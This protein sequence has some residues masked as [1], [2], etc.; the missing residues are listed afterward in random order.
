[1]SFSRIRFA[2]ILLAAALSTPA[3]AATP[4]P[5]EKINVNEL[6]SE[7]QKTSQ[8]P[9][10]VDL[11][12][13]IPEQFWAA[14]MAQD[15]NPDPR[16]TKEL[17]EVFRRNV[18]VATL[19]GE[20][21]VM[22]IGDFE[23]EEVLRGK[24]RVLGPDGKLLAPI[25]A[26]KVERKLDMLIQI[27]RPMFKSLLGEV[28]NNLQFY[29]FPAEVGGKPVVNPLGQGTFKVML[30]QTPYEFRLPLGSLLVPQRDPSTGEAFPGS[31]SFNP[32][33]GTPLTAESP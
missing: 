12:W 22:G 26:D 33:T 1:M 13:W 15:K 8:D 23:S 6:V 14:A 10:S 19:K 21:G 4:L 5:P 18:L 28:G 31:Y 24:L 32:Y 9:D 27:M 20:M 30:A 2:S 3:F 25:P 29:V 17:T 11:V 7:L 16:A